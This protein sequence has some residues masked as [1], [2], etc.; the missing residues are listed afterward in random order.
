V[1]SAGGQMA[2][3]EATMD[4]LFIVNQHAADEKYNF[5]TLQQT[6]SIKS[7]NLFRWVLLCLHMTGVLLHCSFKAASHG[8]NGVG[9]FARNGQHRCPE[10]EWI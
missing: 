2:S 6:T 3:T 1:A 10:A 8:V 9:R 7:Q 4:D 5:E